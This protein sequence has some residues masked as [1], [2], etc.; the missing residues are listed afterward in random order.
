MQFCLLYSVR[1]LRYRFFQSKGFFSK[2]RKT[3]HAQ[4]ISNFPT[5]LYWTA[6]RLFKVTIG[7]AER[8][9]SKYLFHFVLL[10]YMGK[11]DSVSMRSLAICPNFEEFL[12]FGVVVAGTFD[13]HQKSHSSLLFHV[14]QDLLKG[15]FV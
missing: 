4:N 3:R 9:Q 7:D 14:C 10:I 11:Y 1:K 6:L 13:R 15:C 2:R 5:S 8:F 12:I